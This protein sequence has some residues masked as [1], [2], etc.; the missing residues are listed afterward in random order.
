MKEPV[1]WRAGLR[2][3]ASGHQRSE[4]AQAKAKLARATPFAPKR[5]R[6]PSRR[7]RNVKNE[8]QTVRIVI[9]SKWERWKVGEFVCMCAR[10]SA[11]ALA[12]AT[13]RGTRGETEE[14]KKRE[15][16]RGCWR[17][18]VEPVCEERPLG[19][20]HRIVRLRSLAFFY[21]QFVRFFFFVFY[22]ILNLSRTPIRNKI[23]NSLRHHCSTL[24]NY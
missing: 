11:C 3:P 12:S 21:R 6:R 4:K 8:G 18:V 16:V 13:E 24:N 15:G 1:Y 2:D 7:G 17:I 10:C 19:V 20:D 9:E 22:Y 23:G 5:E 14:A